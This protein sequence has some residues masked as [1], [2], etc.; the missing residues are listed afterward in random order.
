MLQTRS[1]SQGTGIPTAYPRQVVLV[2]SNPADAA[3]IAGVFQEAKSWNRLVHFDDCQRALT[4]LRGRPEE[5]PMLILL[6]WNGPDGSVFHFLE[7]LRADETLRMIPV[8]VLGQSRERH[9]FSTIF[10]LGVAGYMIKSADPAKLQEEVA[11]I[12][13]YWALSEL[14][15]S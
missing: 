8:V 3:L 9:D 2:E 12:C 10:A 7:A 14:P 4:H 11:A 15:R 5:K 13:T 1:P 6:A